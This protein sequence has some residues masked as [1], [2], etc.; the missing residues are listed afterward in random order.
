MSEKVCVSLT[1]SKTQRLAPCYCG[2]SETEEVHTPFGHR[3]VCVFDLVSL[4]VGNQDCRGCGCVCEHLVT[5]C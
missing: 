4:L 3:T 5:V 1:D 2:H